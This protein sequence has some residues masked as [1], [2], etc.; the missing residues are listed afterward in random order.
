LTNLFFVIDLVVNI[1]TPILKYKQK[2]SENLDSN[3]KFHIKCHHIED[4]VTRY[5][6]ENMKLKHNFHFIFDKYGSAIWFKITQI[7]QFK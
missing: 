5:K 3:L 4:H 2:K 1:Y 6:L 7:S